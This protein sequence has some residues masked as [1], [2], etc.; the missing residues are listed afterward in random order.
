MRITRRE[1]AAFAAGA[2][3]S[4]ASGVC[5]AEPRIA[6]PD[7][8]DT[9]NHIMGPI[10]K[11]PMSPKRVYTPPEAS[12]AQ[13]KALRAEIGTSRNVLVQPSIYGFD[14]SC[15]LDAM[16]ELGNSVRGIAVLPPDVADAELHRLAGLGVKGIR[17]NVAQATVKDP[18]G[19]IDLINAFAPRF[20]ALGWHIQIVCASSV[21]AD[22]APSVGHLPIPLVFD[23]FGGAVAAEGVQQKGFQALLELVRAGNTYVKLS[24]PYDRSKRADYADVLPFARALV[25]ARPDR[26]LW[27]TNWPHPDAD[28][29]RPALE[30]SPYQKIDNLKLVAALYQWCPDDGMRKAILVD[31]PAKLYGFA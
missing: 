6:I 3:A 7:A 14:N 30:L 26:M 31:N 29:G 17:L 5:A 24:A 8:T 18:K 20:P 27:G 15:M 1:F 11:Y 13:L 4:V 21:V 25:A 23:H 22:I 9:H 10:A 16:K 19:L 2:A 12:V 28:S